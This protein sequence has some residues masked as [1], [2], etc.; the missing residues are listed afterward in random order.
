[1]G[2]SCNLRRSAGSLAEQFDVL[3]AGKLTAY[4][5]SL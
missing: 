5:V 3:A 4:P 1:M 2:G